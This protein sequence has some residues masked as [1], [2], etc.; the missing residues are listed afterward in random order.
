MTYK[1]ERI[2]RFL[3][4]PLL[5]PLCPQRLARSRRSLNIWRA[6]EL[7][8]CGAEH[9]GLGKPGQQRRVSP[10]TKA[11]RARAEGCGGRCLRGARGGGAGA[12]GSTCAVRTRAGPGRAGWAR[13]VC[14][15]RGP[16]ACGCPGGG[17]SH[18]GACLY[19]RRQARVRRRPASQPL[20]DPTRAPPTAPQP[21]P[22][23]E[24]AMS[25]PRCA[26]LLLLLL[27]PPLL[28][29]PPAG[30]AAVIT[31]VSGPRC[32]CPPGSRAP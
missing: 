18:C 11:M 14:P 3:S 16:R 6:N 1:N 5:P 29:K 15:R 32:T 20:R 26:P 8:V 22:R 19:S 13:E 31:G 21:P 2:E 28:L 9:V 7:Q 25:S 24:G 10:T 17:V 23:P 27:L 4:P 12:R 30:D